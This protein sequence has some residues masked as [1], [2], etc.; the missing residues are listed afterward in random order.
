MI[1]FFAKIK[2]KL[3]NK[4]RKTILIPTIDPSPVENETAQREES[5][6]VNTINAVPVDVLVQLLQYL[7]VSK[8]LLNCYR[9]LCV[10]LC[11]SASVR[12]EAGFVA[13]WRCKL[14]ISFQPCQ[15]HQTHGHAHLR[16]VFTESIICM[17]PLLR[18]ICTLF[19]ADELSCST[20]SRL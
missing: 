19:D 6:P 20:V 17:L 5:E 15:L 3:K 8:E 14:H 12:R 7:N 11:K 16:V 10:K 18:C 1:R 13:S 2:R 4:S 9:I